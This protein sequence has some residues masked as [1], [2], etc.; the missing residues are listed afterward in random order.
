MAESNAIYMAEWGDAG[1]MQ[2]HQIA[3]GW[4]SDVTVV[5]TFFIENFSVQQA[6]INNALKAGQSV[7]VTP[8]VYSVLDRPN[9]ST[10]VG[11][12]F[13]LHYKEK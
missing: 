1:A 5:N 2:Y 13:Q 7:Y 9:N 4:R 3:N 12:G 8:S 6:L 10:P 11:H